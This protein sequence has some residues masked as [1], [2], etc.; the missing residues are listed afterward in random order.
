MGA[1]MP[2]HLLVL[3]AILGFAAALFKPEGLTGRQATM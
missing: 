3:V 1:A 2:A